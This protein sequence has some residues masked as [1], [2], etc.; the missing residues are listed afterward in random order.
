MKE[1]N[2]DLKNIM[3]ELEKNIKNQE[4]LEYIKSKFSNMFLEVL[5]NLATKIENL[6]QKQQELEDSVNQIEKELFI[7]EDFTFEIVCPYCNIEFETDIKD[8]LTEVKCPECGNK[9]ELDW[10]ESEG[11]G[12]MGNCSGCSGCSDED[13][14]M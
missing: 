9:I 11:I 1:I 12:C 8:D 3:D 10:N 14:D 5:N 6:E 2:E 13:D 4:D 7:E